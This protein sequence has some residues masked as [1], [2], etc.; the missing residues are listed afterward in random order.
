[1]LPLPRYD[2]VDPKGH[3]HLCLW[4][5]NLLPLP[6]LGEKGAVMGT[7]GLG[8]VREGQDALSWDIRTQSENQ[9]SNVQRPF[10]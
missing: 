9:S 4:P 1:M 10:G 7:A 5:E 2:L 8:G 3:P 6:V